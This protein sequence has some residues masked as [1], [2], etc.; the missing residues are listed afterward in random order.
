MTNIITTSKGFKWEQ[1][2][3]GWLD[4]AT[5][6]L[7]YPAETKVYTRNATIKEFN[8]HNKRIPTTNEWKDACIHEVH[9]L[10]AIDREWG[11]PSSFPK[12]ITG[13]WIFS[14]EA[15]HNYENGFVRCV[16]NIKEAKFNKQL[17]KYLT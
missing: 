10:Y 2:P 8:T 4:T 9:E 12:G 15:E 7:W 11:F 1:R 3:E 16:C 13:K 6:L 14:D 17:K 5:G